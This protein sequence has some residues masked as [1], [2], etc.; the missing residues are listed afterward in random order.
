MVA[1]S[2]YSQRDAQSRVPAASGAVAG[3][4]TAARI[5]RERPD[6]AG[7]SSTT[8]TL[9]WSWI[10]EAGRSSVTGPST[11][12]ATG[13]A[14]CSPQATSTSLAAAPMVATPW[15]IAR[16]GTGRPRG[17]QPGVV[18]PGSL[19]QLHHPGGAVQRRAGLVEG[20]VAIGSDSQQLQP[21]LRI[22]DLTLIAGAFGVGVGRVGVRAV[23][24]VRPDIHVTSQ[25]PVRNV[26]IGARVV[27]GQR[28][29][30][31][32]AGARGRRRN[33]VPARG[34]AGPARRRSLHRCAGGQAERR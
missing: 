29:G 18:G 7:R 14:L 34:G 30:T 5:E 1:S 28:R 19:A 13:W 27:P 32:R 9:G 33:S 12:R 26:S 21:D 17:K 22:S 15:V 4:G 16:A 24:G 6:E 2:W 3:C 20:D 31:H 8:V 25:Q 11:A 10:A 23:D